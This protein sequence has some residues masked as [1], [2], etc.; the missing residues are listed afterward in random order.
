MKTERKKQQRGVR[1]RVLDVREQMSSEDVEETRGAHLQHTRADAPAT[2][3][4]AWPPHHQHSHYR[5]RD[6]KRS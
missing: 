3:L 2:G 1:A 6:G 5:R 4:L